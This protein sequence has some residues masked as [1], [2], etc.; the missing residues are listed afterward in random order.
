HDLED[1]PQKEIAQILEIPLGTV[2][3]RLH[4]ARKTMGQFLQKQ[5]VL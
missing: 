1:L 2:K 4:Y 5:G 3:S